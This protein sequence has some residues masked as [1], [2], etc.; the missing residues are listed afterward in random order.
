MS[1]SFTMIYDNDVKTV[2]SDGT[3]GGAAAQIQELLGIGVSLK[4]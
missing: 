2:K 4:L 1:L 3:P